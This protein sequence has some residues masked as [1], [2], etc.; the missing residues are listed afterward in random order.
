MIIIRYLLFLQENTGKT[1]V[2]Q[3]FF[4]ETFV[5]GN[6][7]LQTILKNEEE[8]N[9]LLTDITVNEAK[10]DA[11]CMPHPSEASDT[12]G[13]MSKFVLHFDMVILMAVFSIIFGFIIV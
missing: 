4:N 6:D 11:L 5:G 3:I 7:S 8:W 2:P 12:V 10:E 1:S 13:K 9:R